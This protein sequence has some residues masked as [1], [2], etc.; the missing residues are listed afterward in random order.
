MEKIKIISD[1]KHFAQS[2]ALANELLPLWNYERNIILTCGTEFAEE[3]IAA[4]KTSGAVLVSLLDP[5]KNHDEF[6]L[7]IAPE[8]EPLP[9]GNVITTVGLINGI[10]PEV[11]KE[12]DSSRFKELPSPRIAVL[13]GGRHVGGNFTEDDAFRMAEMINGIGGSALVTTSRR[14]EDKSAKALK[15]AINLPM[16]FWDYNHEGQAA[17]PYQEILAVAEIIIVTADSVR[18]CSEACSSG[19]KVTIFTPQQVHFSYIALRD[20]LVAKGYAVLSP[21]HGETKVLNEARRVAEAISE[22]F[23]H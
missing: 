11:L 14:T 4:K 1:A 12:I 19:K 6:D 2:R 22:K 9:P 20:L 17:N 8:H 7:I 5:T 15:E 13:A 16:F 3:A 21:Q 18:M 23:R 10:N